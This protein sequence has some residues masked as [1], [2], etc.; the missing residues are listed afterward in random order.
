MTT[1]VA[2]GGGGGG[3]GGSFT[4]GTSTV[5]DVDNNTYNTVQIGT[6]CWMKENLRT[7]KKPDGSAI[8]KGPAAHAGG[9]WGTDIGLYSCPP[10]AGNN[11]EDCAAAPIYGMLYQWSAAMNGSTT[12]GAQG[13]C[14]TGWHV[15]TDAEFKT[16]IE[17]QAITPGCESTTTAGWY[18][19]GAAPKLA[20][21]TNWGGSPLSTATN[22]SG[23]SAQPSGGRST[24]SDYY[25]RTY[26]TFLWSSTQADAS[27]AWH[28][29]FN[30]SR[31]SVQRNS[32]AKAHGFSL[33]CIQ[34]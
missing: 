6:Q 19:S 12:A 13:I 26:D 18:C 11:G 10:N 15:P 8:T 9:G 30:Y 25:N 14:P 24:G 2:S 17:S 23:F 3:G 32:L 29:H 34:G 20:I 4:C 27:S 5:T 28:R 22:T 21:A 1:A 16:L 31:P 7:T 33:R